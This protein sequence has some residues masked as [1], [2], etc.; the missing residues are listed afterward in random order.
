MKQVLKYIVPFAEEHAALEQLVRALGVDTSPMVGG[1]RYAGFMGDKLVCFLDAKHTQYVME[2]HVIWM[3]WATPK[4]RMECFKWAMENLGQGR[5]ILLMI[6]KEH[7]SL[8][9]HFAKR[10]YL[11]KIGF[12]DNLPKE[13]GEEIHMYQYVRER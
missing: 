5:E 9:E 13:A 12:I 3:P 8:F 10:K 11:R 2:P 6:Q 7:N 1:A 4:E